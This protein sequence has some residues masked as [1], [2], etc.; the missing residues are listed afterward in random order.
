MEQRLTYAAMHAHKD[1]PTRKKH[2]KKMFILIAA[3]MVMLTAAPFI[4]GNAAPSSSQLGDTNIGYSSVKS[5]NDTKSHVTDLNKTILN[6]V[7]GAG[8]IIIALGVIKLIISL[9]DHSPMGKMNAST[10]IGLGL[11]C[12][13]GASILETLQPVIDAADTPE[14]QV[15]AVI[16]LISDAFFWPGVILIVVAIV[17]MI[18]AFSEERPE[19]K[20]DSGKMFAA[21]LAVM[22]LSYI[23]KG[24]SAVAFKKDAAVE[25][26][27][28]IVNSVVFPMSVLVGAPLMLFGVLQFASAF[29][30]ED[31]AGKHRATLMMVSALMLTSIGSILS[32]F[33]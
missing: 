12:I 32:I 26:T 3:L 27:K 29:K 24:I 5:S 25:I 18:L 28:Y 8:V 11:V 30:D 14:T 22:S 19:G 9:S 31:A 13:G 17:K 2:I 10:T 20:M 21:G 1:M 16:D 4:E 23:L 15:D 33:T 7:I 6:L